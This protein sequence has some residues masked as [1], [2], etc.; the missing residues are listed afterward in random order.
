MTKRD[1]KAMLVSA[2]KASASEEFVP[3]TYPVAPQ[4][5]PDVDEK[6]PIIDGFDG[7]KY[8][9]S[10]FYRSDM[11]REIN[12]IIKDACTAVHVKP[13]NE[14]VDVLGMF[15]EQARNAYSEIENTE[16][17]ILDNKCKA[18]FDI[19]MLLLATLCMSTAKMKGKT[20]K[21]RMHSRLVSN[22]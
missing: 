5:I 15:Y 17:A 19:G 6:A 10:D 20:R 4:I 16:I 3:V 2:K 13:S 8:T 21:R 9:P 18:I 7:C 14:A 12:R 22:K 1:D 11:Q